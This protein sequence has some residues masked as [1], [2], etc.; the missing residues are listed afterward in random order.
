[1][2]PTTATTGP[3]PTLADAVRERIGELHDRGVRTFT[4]ADFRG[5]ARRAGRRD[6][7]LTSH[8]LVLEG[9]GILEL[10]SSSGPRAWRVAPGSEYLR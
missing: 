10:S 3:P 8:L 7:W 5:V 6:T 1:M 4:A 9:V 2:P